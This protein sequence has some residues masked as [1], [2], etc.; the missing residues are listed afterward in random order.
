MRLLAWLLAL[1]GLVVATT[2]GDAGEKPVKLDALD[3]VGYRPWKAPRVTSNYP[4]LRPTWL[5]TMS[6]GRSNLQIYSLHVSGPSRVSIWLKAHKKSQ[7]GLLLT[8]A[9]A[10]APPRGLR[11]YS[12][13][14]YDEW[15]FRAD[16]KDES[17]TCLVLQGDA[18]EEG[19]YHLGIL[20]GAA[21]ASE[22]QSRNGHDWQIQFD[23]TLE[24]GPT[25]SHPN[26]KLVVIG[27]EPVDYTPR[28]SLDY[29]DADNLG[30]RIG[31]I[32]DEFRHDSL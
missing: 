9:D 11:R 2:P 21:F 20:G 1:L 16:A 25:A 19:V 3:P 23:G 29:Q 17:E 6:V 32:E 8:K 26:V 27:D 7:I 12:P 15:H 14:E 22:N 4:K 31:L 10:P 30:E 24:C 28:H 13:A 5:Y 18:L